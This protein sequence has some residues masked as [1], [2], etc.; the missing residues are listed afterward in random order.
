[1]SIPFN[2][3]LTSQYPIHIYGWITLM[4]TTILFSMIWSNW[5]FT[6]PVKVYTVT[7][8]INV[9]KNETIKQQFSDHSN[10]LKSY[11]TK[12][13]CAVFPARE[14]KKIKTG[15]SAYLF[16][17]NDQGKRERIPATVL[18]VSYP[19]DKEMGQV[20]LEA[21]AEYIDH[22]HNPF[23]N[24]KM[25]HVKINIDELTPA[26]ILFRASGLGIDTPNITSTYHNT[27]VQ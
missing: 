20:V 10:H 8:N 17:D 1:M 5:F 24:A 12:Q 18:N 25:R 3:I 13:L 4:M 19:G 7:P 15:Q 23:K 11:I 6:F 2:K 22:E 27:M 16:L 26:T 9:Q 21:N 14:L